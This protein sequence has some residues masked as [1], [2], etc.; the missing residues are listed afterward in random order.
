[1]GRRFDRVLLLVLD[2]VGLGALPDAAAYGDEGSDSLG[3][4]ARAVGG[5]EVPHLARRGLGRIAHLPRWADC[6]VTGAYGRLFMAAAGKDST[7]GHWEL[8]GLVLQKSFPLFPEGFPAEAVAA[9][10]SAT[11]C[12]FLGNR[13]ASGTEIIAELGAEHL[14]TGALIL[15]TSAD[16]VCQIAA[17]V[18]LLPPEELCRCGARAR[19]AMTG[20]YAVGRVIV[21]PFEGT[22]GAFRRIDGGR[23]DF[24]LPPPA[25]TLLDRLAEAGYAV[26]GIG[27]VD[28]IFAGRGFTSAVP[29]RDNADGIAKIRE[30]LR[31]EEAGLIFANLNDFDTAFGHRNDVEGYAQALEQFDAALPEL[32]SETAEVDLVLIVSD[33]GNDPTTPSTDHSRECTPLLAWHRRL[34]REVPLGTRGTFADVGQ[35]IADNFDAGPL[36][37]GASFLNAIL[38]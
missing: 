21:R 35:T 30:A 8:A 18:D 9:L 1:M 33:H 28:Q 3:H 7:S 27:K 19:G 6:A 2:G 17:H 25:P 31:K 23:R 12:K 16:S 20:P 14:R 26:R 32:E 36:D 34:E 5:L 37:A 4:V 10:E 22:P 29:T 24:A 38:V 15:Y 11:S 13:A